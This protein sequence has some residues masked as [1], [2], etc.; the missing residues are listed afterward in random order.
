V[1]GV[2]A[3]RAVPIL[4]VVVLAVEGLLLYRHYERY[5]G[6]NAASGTAS[7][8]EQAFEGTMPGGTVSEG[9]T[10]EGTTVT[11]NVSSDADGAAFVHRATEDNS[12]GD[13][14]YLAHP[15]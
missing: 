2:Y 4:V 7:S 14:T 8:A 11:A 10:L 3:K 13:Y 15:G 1:P 12:R 9:T 5:H 6:A